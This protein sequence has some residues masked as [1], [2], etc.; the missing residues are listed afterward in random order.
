MLNIGSGKIT[1]KKW[2]VLPITVLMLFRQRKFSLSW[3][4]KSAPKSIEKIFG[5]NKTPIIVGG[6]GLYIQALVDNIVLPEVKPNW[7]LRKELEKKTTEEMFAMLKKLDPERAKNIDA[8][9]PRRLIRA[10]EIAKI[11]GKIPHLEAPLPSYD[12][13]QIG[14]KLPDEILKKSIDKRIK[15]II[16]SGTCRRNRKIK[17]VGLVLEKN[18]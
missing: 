6:T 12:V 9:N 8:K 10:I 16:K 3:I 14:I 13:L 17:K 11:L 7:K 1:K 15:K 18:L 4:L 2:V 5:K